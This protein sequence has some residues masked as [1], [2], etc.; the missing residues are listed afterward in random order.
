VHV[1]EVQL[2]VPEAARQ[3]AR[4]GLFT[5]IARPE[6][7][8]AALALRG[9]VASVCVHAAD[10]AAVADW[11]PPYPVDLWLTTAKCAAHLPPGS[12]ALVVEQRLV[13]PPSLCAELERLA[14][15]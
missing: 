7:L 5:A 15:V 10:H 11:P 6:R 9:V 12:G 2:E 14:A 1:A 4:L 8:V 3:A 13:L